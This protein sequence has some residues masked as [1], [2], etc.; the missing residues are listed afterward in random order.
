VSVQLGQRRVGARQ[1]H[2]LRVEFDHV[3]P[4]YA[5][6]PQHLAYGE[7][8]AA[9]E[10]EHARVRAVH[11]GVDEGFVVAALVVAADPE[12]AVEEEAER[13]AVG[14]AG[15]DDLLDVGVHRDPY[16]PAVHR[17]PC[18]SFEVVDEDGGRG[19]HREDDEVGDDEQPAAAPGQVL[20]E[21][22]EYE[23]A[24]RERVDGS[25]DECRGQLAEQGQEKEGERESADQRAHVVRGEQVCDRAARVLPPDALDQLHQQG[26][27]GAD[28]QADGERERDEEI[29][30]AARPR[31]APVA[32]PGE[33]GVQ[34]HRAGAADECEQG[35]DRAEACR[36]AAAQAFGDE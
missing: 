3:D 28:E 26:D 12:A 31:A 32:G 30:G 14:A 10:D 29:A 21:Q 18:G 9:A 22:A 35:L 23:G 4:P 15:E 8:V 6:M 27:F 36:G 33:D 17:V 1:L 19:E 7:S 34:G 11:R 24:A 20:P 16:V 5:R 13:A 25:G 2:E